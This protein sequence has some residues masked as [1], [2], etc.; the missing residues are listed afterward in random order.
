MKKTDLYRISLFDILLVALI[1]VSPLLSL[2]SLWQPN[3]VNNKL[4][5]YYDNKLLASCS[6]SEEGV[7]SITE[8]SSDV[9]VKIEEN[10]VRIL[11]SNCPKQICVHTGWISAPGQTVVCVPNRILLEIKGKQEPKYHAESY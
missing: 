5:L 1:L 7:L 10:R 4:F 6:L 8:K 11:E 9:K 3:Q 2:T